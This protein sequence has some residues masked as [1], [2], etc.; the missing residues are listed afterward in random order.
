MYFSV[1]LHSTRD[2]MPSNDTGKSAGTP[3]YM[4]RLPEKNDMRGMDGELSYLRK[5]PTGTVSPPW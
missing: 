1:F 4:G 5:Y 3:S 2:H